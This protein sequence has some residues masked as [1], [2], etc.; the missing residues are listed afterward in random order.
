MHRNTGYTTTIQTPILLTKSSKLKNMML[1]TS[2][3]LH[4][5]STLFCSGWWIYVGGSSR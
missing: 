4:C 1:N 5:I 3:F 2:V